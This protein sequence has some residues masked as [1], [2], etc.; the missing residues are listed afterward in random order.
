MILLNNSCFVF[1]ATFVFR[2]GVSLMRGYKASFYRTSSIVA[3]FTMGL[4]LVFADRFGRQFQLAKR[5]RNQL[6][7]GHQVADLRDVLEFFRRGTLESKY[8]LTRNDPTF[9]PDV[10]EQQ[11]EWRGTWAPW[12]AAGELLSST[13]S[14]ATAWCRRPQFLKS[15]RMFPYPAIL[16]LSP[17]IY[18][19]GR[20]AFLRAPPHQ[21]LHEQPQHD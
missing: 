14:P 12:A 3:L 20:T 10:S 9:I 4:C 17:R 13:T 2:N 21:R 16:G 7:F 18:L 1:F 11:I 8:M 19:T 5:Q 6:E 15:S